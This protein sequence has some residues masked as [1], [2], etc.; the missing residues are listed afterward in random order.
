MLVLIHND[1][2]VLLH[3]SIYDLFVSLTMVFSKK[4]NL[5]LYLFKSAY[6]IDD[7]VV[8]VKKYILKFPIIIVKQW[9]GI[10]V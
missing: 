1:I 8:F 2:V 5:K 10:F 6:N 3:L 7:W 4:M 9:E